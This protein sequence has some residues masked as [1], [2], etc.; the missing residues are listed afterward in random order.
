MRGVGPGS[1][2]GGRYTVRR[3]L[4][5]LHASERWSADDTTLGRTVSLLCIASDDH[6]TPALLDAARRAASVT[7][8]AFV[9]ILDVGTDE[10]VSYVIEEDLGEAPTLAE[11]VGRGGVPGD[12]VRRITGEV[13]AALE[14]AGQRGM[15]HLDLKPDDV[16]RTPDGDIRLRGLETAAVRAGEDGTEAEDAARRDA[17]GIVAL[18]YAGLTGLWPLGAGGCGLGPAPRVP[19]GVAAPSEIAAGVPRDL[20]AICRL[21]LNDDQGPT[22]P[23]DYARQVAPWPSRQVVGQPVART[24]ADA[25]SAAP[26]SG[27]VGVGAPS[28][29]DTL[30]QPVVVV[31]PAGGAPAAD[32]RHRPLEGAATAA[33]VAGGAAGAAAAGTASGTATDVSGA[34]LS[35]ADTEADATTRVSPVADHPP[36]WLSATPV[37]SPTADP[38]ADA[39]TRTLEPARPSTDNADRSVEAEG[40]TR[41]TGAAAGAAAAGAGAAVV[42]AFGSVGGRVGDLARRA[43]DKVSELSPDTAPRADSGG[44]EAPA[45]LVPA[46]P[47]TKDESKLA[48]GIVVAFVVLALVIGVWGVSRIGSN[49][50]SLSDAAAPATRTTTVAPSSAAPSASASPSAT[51]TGTGAPPE[52]LAILKV[53]AYD[54]EGDGAENNRLTPKVYDGDPSTGWFSEN[55]RSD[56]FG[57]LKK[58]VGVIVDLGPNKKPQT[59]ELTI[60]QPSDVEVYVGPDNRLEGATKI[61]EKADADGTVTFDVPADVSG[62]YIVVWFTKL[63]ADDNGKRRAWLDEVVVTG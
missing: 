45:P 13:A 15:H 31:S 29:P 33:A 53:E 5:Q 9:R 6:R 60:P 30:E 58:G 2:L 42:G 27:P 57:G 38:E 1:V 62:Q 59:V 46:E 35:P 48:L 40:P 32:P 23:G 20:D 7:H 28:A 56:T 22:S 26:R 51:G 47:L 41:S 55:Y 61:G 11:L 43:V 50:P 37:G 52:P 8:G 44:L 14:S 21:T 54:P 49:S 17:V 25:G 34:A 63:N 19:G 16:L 10:G 39:V 4:E 18:A 12:E 36:A 24:A 3:R